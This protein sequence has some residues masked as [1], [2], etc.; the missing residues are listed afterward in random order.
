VNT[1]DDR[2]SIHMHLC[3]VCANWWEHLS[4]R[5]MAD[6]ELTC[7]ECEQAAEK[8]ELDELEREPY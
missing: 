6:M 4:R 3:K 8:R 2:E 5:C 1:P 7:A